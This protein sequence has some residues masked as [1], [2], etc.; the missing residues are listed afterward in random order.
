MHREIYTC[1]QFNWQQI[2]HCR[3]MYYETTQTWDMKSSGTK[4]KYQAPYI[5]VTRSCL[6]E[7]RY[8]GRKALASTA[9]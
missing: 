1:I 8:T 5:S 6:C 4:H 7:P 3:Y 9:E 2:L